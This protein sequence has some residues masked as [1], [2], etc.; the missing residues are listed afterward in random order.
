M[1]KILEMRQIS[2]AFYGV[3]A[4][5]SVDF[6]VLRERH[7]SFLAKTERESPLWLRS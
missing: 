5:K 6:S 3:Q 1:Q 4:L 7:T 2:K